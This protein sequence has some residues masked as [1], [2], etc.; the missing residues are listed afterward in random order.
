MNLFVLG[1]ILASLALGQRLAAFAPSRTIQIS[2]YPA[3]APSAHIG[4]MQQLAFT[5][6]PASLDQWC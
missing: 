4:H 2:L 1:C 3:A 5:Q 6:K